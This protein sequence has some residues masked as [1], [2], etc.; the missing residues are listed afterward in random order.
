MK[1]PFSLDVVVP[2]IVEFGLLRAPNEACGL[3]IPNL[4]WP[5]D[6]WVHELK[7]RSPSPTDSYVFD[8]QT[9]KDLLGNREVWEDILV[10]HT[11]P[12]GRVGPSPEDMNA[13]HPKLQGKYLVISLPRGEAVLF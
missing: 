10:W 9:L 8:P 12:G 7:N 3:V 11:H 4:D 6:M 13:R 2:R 1:I 5:I